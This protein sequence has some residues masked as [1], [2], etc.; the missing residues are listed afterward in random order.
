MKLDNKSRNV[1]GTNI[2]VAFLVAAFCLMSFGLF[3]PVQA[4]AEEL[5]G[6]EAVMVMSTGTGQIQMQPDERK[7]VTL[8][9]Q[10]TGSK[11]WSNDGPGYI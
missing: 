1:I 4:Q 7:T 6:Y 2:M 9:F 8:H 3:I 5:K 10:N 11:T